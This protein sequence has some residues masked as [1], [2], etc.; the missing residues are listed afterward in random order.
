MEAAAQLPTRI[1]QDRDHTHG[2]LGVVAAMPERV[3]GGRKELQ[4]PEP[5]VHREGERPRRH[6]G[7]DDDKRY[8][9]DKSRERRQYDAE[10]RLDHTRPDDRAD[11]DMGDAGTEQPA[12]QGMR[13]ACRERKKPA[14]DIPDY[15][16]DQR[17][18]NHALINRTSVDDADAEGLRD[19][20]SE[21]GNR[22]EIENRGP[23]DGRERAQHAGRDD[24]GNRVCRVGKAV[25]KIKSER[26]R[27]KPD[28]H[29]ECQRRA[30]HRRP[31]PVTGAT[32]RQA[33]SRTMLWISFPISSK[34][35]ITAS[36]GWEISL[37]VTKAIGSSVAVPL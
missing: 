13:T 14:R 36:R 2:L 21:H 31:A 12:D 29:R 10:G 23:D 8:R 4:M 35:S 17:A 22:N 27:D 20:Q 7:D 32:D 37:P 18:E 33:C 28:E 24:G 5:A 34:Q 15:G 11:A 9:D 19:V 16:S 30:G 1:E 3:Q 25:Q 26:Q 6:S